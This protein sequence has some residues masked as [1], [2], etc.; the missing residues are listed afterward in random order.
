MAPDPKDRRKHP[1][2]INMGT[3]VCRFAQHR[4]PNVKST[5][6]DILKMLLKARKDT[7][8][9]QKGEKNPFLWE[10]LEAQQLA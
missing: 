10:L 7:R 4:D 2:K 6:P 3:R 5:I 8:R 1:E 9:K